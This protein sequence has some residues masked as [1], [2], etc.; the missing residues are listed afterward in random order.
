MSSPQTSEPL[1]VAAELPA[2]RLFTPPAE[3][4]SRPPAAADGSSAPKPPPLTLAAAFERYV[5]PDMQKHR[6]AASTIRDVERSVERWRVYW[7]GRKAA[8]IAAGREWILDPFLA[9]HVRLKHLEQW[10]AALVAETKPDGRPRYSPASVNRMLGGIRQVLRACERRG[11]LK[12]ARPAVSKLAARPAPKFYMRHEQAESLWRQMDS[13]TWPQLPGMT[14][15]DWWRCALVLYWIYGF[16]TQ[17]LIAF[18]VG[19]TPLTWSAISLGDET[20]NPEG[21]ATNALGW[22]SYVPQKQKWAKPE[23]LYLPL[24]RHTRAAV[25]RLRA[26]AAIATEGE[27]EASRPLFPWPG[28]HKIIYRQWN[29]LQTAAGIT[30]KSGAPF[31]LK[32]LRK[33]AATYLENHAKG[34]GAAVCGWADRN[35]SGVMATHYAVNELA[36]VE[37]LATYPVPRC[38]DELLS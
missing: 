4:P 18:Q 36:I 37:Q 1:P 20:P 17:E 27:P 7:E 31:L 12:K 21:T 8:T 13:A 15:A 26:A 10:Q 16:R 34:L 5:R 24:T 19:K 6:R 30:T 28:S 33:T 14:P 29:A 11:K 22:L 32:H 25:D 23:P 3:P 9:R 35:V 38:F 2:L